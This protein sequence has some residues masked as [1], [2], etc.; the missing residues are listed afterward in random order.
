MHRLLVAFAQPASVSVE[1]LS[2]GDITIL[3]QICQQE[4]C[5]SK[6]AC[7]PR[8]ILVIRF[9][10]ILACLLGVYKGCDNLWVSMTAPKTPTVISIDDLV[11]NP[12]MKLPRY[13]EFKG[14]DASVYVC[15]EALGQ[16]AAD[17]SPLCKDMK[18]PLLSQR[19][20]SELDDGKQVHAAAIY[21]ATDSLVQRCNNA[22][23]SNCLDGVTF[24]GVSQGSLINDLDD[25]D[26]QTL[27]DKKIVV[28]SDTIFIGAAEALPSSGGSSATI[29][30]SL[31][32]AFAFIFLWP[33][34]KAREEV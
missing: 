27:V 25:K 14:V 18:I 8:R 16:K 19:Q 24:R 12:H 1:N 9:I 28:D 6:I 32:F 10:L 4:D 30:I 15:K 7:R 22:T 23:D 2:A 3:P 13:L 31:L 33:K 11:A 20:T 21:Q 5:F 34:K 17:G 29:V 26:K